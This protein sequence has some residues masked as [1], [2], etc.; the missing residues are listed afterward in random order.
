MKHSLLFALT[1]SMLTATPAKGLAQEQLYPH[2]FNLSEVTL[3]DSPMKQAMDL[4]IRVLLDYDTDRLLTPF[5]RQA[6]LTTGRYTNWLLLHPN[7]KNWGGN[8]FDL[9]G[10]VGGHYLSA[11]AMAYAAC[12]DHQTRALLK[13]RLDYMLSVLKDCQD[14]YQHDKTGMKG[15]LGGQPINEVW[16]ELYQGNA[17]AF[18]PVRG[19]VPFYCEHKVMA[20]LRDAYLYTS[21]KTAKEMYRK[22]ADWAVALIRHLSTEQM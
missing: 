20:G 15:F 16:R 10:H 2:H 1:A 17:K 19:W 5:I 21:N 3:L 14:V 11:L 6:G 9:S 12:Q 7:F 18:D 13:S 8:G 4:N 22:M